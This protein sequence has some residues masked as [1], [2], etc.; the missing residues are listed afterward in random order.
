MLL[1]ICRHS[2]TL[3]DLEKMCKLNVLFLTLFFFF[4]SFLLCKLFKMN[5][6]YINETE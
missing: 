6:A 2:W 4:F 5:F 3:E 1:E